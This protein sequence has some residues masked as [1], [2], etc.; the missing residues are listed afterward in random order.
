M[1]GRPSFDRPN[2][3]LAVYFYAYLRS[4]PVVM[5]E[6]GSNKEA[7]ADRKCSNV[8]I[9]MIESRIMIGFLHVA[10]LHHGN[11]RRGAL[12]QRGIKYC[13]SD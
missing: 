9:Q 8:L 3:A 5:P 6:V 13:L 11:S 10:R 1:S 12:A 4:S 2:S 7:A